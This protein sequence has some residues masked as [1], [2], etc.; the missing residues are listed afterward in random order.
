MRASRRDFNHFAQ[1]VRKVRKRMIWQVTHIHMTIDNS[2]INCNDARKSELDKTLE[3][4]TDLLCD[5]LRESNPDFD[6]KK[7]KAACGYPEDE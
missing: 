4:L 5:K 1:I 7:F 6:P 2:I 3:I